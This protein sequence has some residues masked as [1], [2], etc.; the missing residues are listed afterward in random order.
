M[1]KGAASSEAM[2]FICDAEWQ[3]DQCHD[4]QGAPCWQSVPHEGQATNG[5]KPWSDTQIAKFKRRYEQE[6]EE[7]KDR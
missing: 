7:S 6:E 2:D 4:G 1:R 3:V 5:S